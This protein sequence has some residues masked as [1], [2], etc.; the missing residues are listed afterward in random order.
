[1][2]AATTA[3]VRHSLPPSRWPAGIGLFTTTFAAGQIVGPIA[4]GAL[5]DATGGLEHALT[6]S[7]IFV[8]AGSLIALRQRI[9]SPPSTTPPA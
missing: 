7:A 5:S 2:V 8:L 6:F 1:V 4:V 3:L 9:F